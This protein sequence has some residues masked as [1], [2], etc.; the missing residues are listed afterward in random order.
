MLQL[1]DFARL[2]RIGLVPVLAESARGLAEDSELRLE[3][4]RVASVHR[5]TVQLHDGE[6]EHP[7]RLLPRLARQLLEG[8]T[9]LAVG[10]WVLA[11][12]DASGARWVQLRAAAAQPHRPPRRRRQSPCGGEQHRLGPARHGPRRRLQP[13]PARALPDAGACQRDRADRRP[14]QGRHR[15]RRPGPARRAARGAR[16][17]A[18]RAGCRPWSSTPPIRR[19][20]R[21]SPTSRAAARRWCCSALRA[22]ASRPS[23]TP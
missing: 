7:A 17:G 23:P 11:S 13:A 20:R 5:E 15:R 6:R 3:L 12:R 18:S 2:Q 16:S 21:A 8:G 19:A 9:M 1:F 4:L 22:P 14:D 10:D